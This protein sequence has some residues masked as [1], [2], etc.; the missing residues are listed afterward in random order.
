MDKSIEKNIPKIKSLLLKY[1][2][3][4]AFLFG[5]VAKGTNSSESD[6]DLLYSFSEELDIE[7]YA[8]NYFKLID[9]L[10]KLLN[11]RVDLVAEKTLKNPYLIESINESKIQL[12]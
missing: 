6:V 11:K 3:K 9:D 8:I 4:R 7:T 2:V 1:G 10:E 5:S 12:L